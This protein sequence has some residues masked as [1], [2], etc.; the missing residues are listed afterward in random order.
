M[1]CKIYIYIE[2]SQGI[3]GTVH[4][5]LT[6]K[7]NSKSYEVNSYK[8]VYGMKVKMGIKASK[9]IVHKFLNT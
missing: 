6:E 2:R 4:Y 1:S 3:E 9:K 5:H 7:L 8:S